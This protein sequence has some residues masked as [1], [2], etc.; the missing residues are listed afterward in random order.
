MDYEKLCS[1]EFLLR[2]C[3]NSEEIP[4]FRLGLYDVV[5]YSG[6]VDVEF[7]DNAVWGWGL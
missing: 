3:L 2:L 5:W 6:V 7:L 1:N 4:D